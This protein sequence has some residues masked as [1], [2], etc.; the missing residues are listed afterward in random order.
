MLYEGGQPGY[1]MPT[2]SHI[3]DGA[4]NDADPVPPAGRV[5]NMKTITVAQLTAGPEQAG[6]IDLLMLVNLPSKMPGLVPSKL[7]TSAQ[8]LATANW[9]DYSKFAPRCTIRPVEIP[10]N[11]NKAS[12]TNPFLFTG[13]TPWSGL[14]TSQAGMLSYYPAGWYADGFVAGTYANVGPYGAVLCRFYL[15]A[16]AGDGF[17]PGAGDMVELCVDFSHT[18]DS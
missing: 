10:L 14:I 6:I 13:A 15:E 7:T 18:I 8:W 16:G 17:V 1:I 11:A 9:P 3:N 2:T 12:A 4:G 5:G